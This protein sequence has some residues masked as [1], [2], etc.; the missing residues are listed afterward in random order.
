MTT[1]QMT[2][3]SKI[4]EALQRIFFNLCAT[5]SELLYMC[6]AAI[7]RRNSMLRSVGRSAVSM[8]RAELLIS[9]QTYSEVVRTVRSS[10][11]FSTTLRLINS[12]G[13][14]VIRTILIGSTLA[15]CAMVL[16][17][18][19]ASRLSETMTEKFTTNL[20]LARASKKENKNK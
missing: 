18:E 3:P 6:R 16:I 1:H 14:L 15:M 7:V 4:Y 9:T 10:N 11:T 8:Y 12:F 19:G 5:L 2:G 20:S 17:V 13:S